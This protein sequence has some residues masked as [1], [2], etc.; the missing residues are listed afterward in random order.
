MKVLINAWVRCDLGM[1]TF[2]LGCGYD[3]TWVWVRVDLGVGTCWLGSGYVLTWHRYDLTWDIWVWVRF[4][5]GWVRLDLGWVRLDLGWV[6]LDLGTCWC[7]YV[8]TRTRWCH[9][10]VPRITRCYVWMIG[11][12]RPRRFSWFGWRNLEID[13]DN[14]I[15]KLCPDV[16]WVIYIY[17]HQ[18]TDNDLVVMH[19]NF[20]K[21]V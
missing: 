15:L 12:K 16:K 8:L 7:G 5:L 14:Y 18:V 9:M 2:W 19:N 11:V 17:I 6:R 3:M 10:E 20:L 4:D 1:G 21:C 13:I